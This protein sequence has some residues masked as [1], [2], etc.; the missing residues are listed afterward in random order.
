MSPFVVIASK[1]YLFFIKII[2][3]VFKRFHVKKYQGI[4]RTMV[5]TVFGLCINKIHRIC[6]FQSN[7]ITIDIK[8]AI[9]GK[10]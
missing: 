3:L 9:S 6:A 5:T 1:Q 10:K 4:K 7:R 8:Y 2:A